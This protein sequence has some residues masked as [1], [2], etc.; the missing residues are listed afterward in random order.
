MYI[1]ECSSWSHEII[2]NMLTESF[3]VA[4]HKYR[5]PIR[6]LLLK[7]VSNAV[8]HNK[9]TK[10]LGC[11]KLHLQPKWTR[12]PF[13]T[14]KS[15]HC[16]P[17]TKTLKASR[18]KTVQQTWTIG[19]S[20]DVYVHTNLSAAALIAPSPSVSTWFW[21]WPILNWIAFAEYIGEPSWKNADL[22]T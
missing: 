15:R 1:L 11:V 12:E 18:C 3:I 19:N 9:H 20:G 4:P 22:Q 17:I 8:F 10:L 6:R 14:K 7:L 2:F 16:N 21:R 13:S 5:I